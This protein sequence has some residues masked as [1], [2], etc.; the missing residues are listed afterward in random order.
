MNLTALSRIVCLVTL[1]CLTSVAGAASWE[2]F[3]GNIDMGGWRVARNSSNHAEVVLLGPPGGRVIV[4]NAAAP[5]VEYLFLPDYI[6]A[7]TQSVSGDSY[8]IIQRAW[9]TSTQLGDQRIVRLSGPLTRAQLEADPAWSD[10]IEGMPFTAPR[11]PAK[12]IFWKKPGIVILYSIIALG[13]LIL[14]LGIPLIAVILVILWFRR[15]KRT[16]ESGTL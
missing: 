6:V 3:P 11:A 1:F 14:L 4:G 12:A 7:R 15:R 13:P 8:Y 5:V 10:Q 9:P 16:G 2:D